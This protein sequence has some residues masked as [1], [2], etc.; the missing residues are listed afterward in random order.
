MPISIALIISAA[1][2]IVVAVCNIVVAACSIAEK[3][4]RHHKRR[5]REHRRRRGQQQQQ[6]K[7]CETTDDT[8]PAMNTRSRRREKANLR[9]NKSSNRVRLK[10]TPAAAMLFD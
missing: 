1:C 7:I 4:R 3:I 8:S 6:Q 9:A 5:R 2:N 10:L